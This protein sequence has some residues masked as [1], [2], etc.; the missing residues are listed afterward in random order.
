MFLENQFLALAVAFG[1]AIGLMALLS[2]FFGVI[3]RSK[4]LS[5]HKSVVH[6]VVF[7]S[8]AVFTM[9]SPFELAP[10]MFFDGRTIFVGLAAA[11]AGLPAAII[12]AVFAGAFRIYAGGIGMIAGTTG[13]IFAAGLGYFWY[14]YVRPAKGLSNVTDLAILG[15][16]L[17][18]TMSA[19]FLLPSELA[20]NALKNVAPLLSLTIMIS[21]VVLGSFMERELRLIASELEWRENAITDDLTGLHNRRKF[22]DDLDAIA[23]KKQP[24]AM[25]ILDIDHFKEINDQYGHAAGDAALVSMAGVLRSSLRATDSVYRIGGEEFA[26]L[27]RGATQ[28]IAQR[29]AAR[30]GVGIETAKIVH[31]DTPLNLTVSIGGKVAMRP[32]EEPAQVFDQADRAVYVAKQAGRNCVQFATEGRQAPVAA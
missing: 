25:L 31:G 29:I 10:G 19:F 5:L 15:G 16:M 26:V 28:Y 9:M 1:Q 24:Y 13:I 12:S 21:A 4:W 32:A 17:C 22:V 11:F 2:I 14:R 23:A 20:F 6:G 30:I 3:E 7:G 27:I 18:F 8:G